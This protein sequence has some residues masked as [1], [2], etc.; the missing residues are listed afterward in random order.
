MAI[1]PES[2]FSHLLHDRGDAHP[3]SDIFVCHVVPSGQIETP[4]QHSH[5]HCVKG[6]LVLGWCRPTLRSIKDNGTYHGLVNLGFHSNGHLS[7]AQDAGDLAPFHPG[8]VDSGSG[9]REGVAVTADDRSKILEIG[10]LLQVFAVNADGSVF[11]RP[12]FH[13]LGLLDV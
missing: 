5:F 4:S 2:S 9:I 7:I 1:P 3:L 10:R 13:I 6:L 11:L 12:A 8:G